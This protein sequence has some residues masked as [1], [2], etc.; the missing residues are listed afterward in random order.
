MIINTTGRIAGDFYML[1]HPAIP[2]YLLDGAQPVIFDAGFSFLGEL[3]ATEVKAVLGDRLPAFC[4]LTHSHFDH[5]GAVATL[6]QHFPGLKVLASAKAQQTLRRPNAIALI[7][8]L[9]RAAEAYARDMGLVFDD[10]HPFQPFEVDQVLREGDRLDVSQGRSIEVIETPGHTWDCLSYYIPSLK[11]LLSS[12]AAGQADSNG[13]IVSD[14]LV[15]YDQ[16]LASIQK[17]SGLAIDLLG[18][19]HLY[20]YTGDDARAYLQQS[21]NTCDEF[22]RLVEACLVQAQGDIQQVMARVRAIEY[23]N[24]S[25]P[26]Q[27]EQA[28]LINLAARIKA[29]AKRMQSQVN[30]TNDRHPL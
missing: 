10:N 1:G 5:C 15:D 2:I 16:Y 27:T 25:G 13:Y 24:N 29:V 14:C 6:Q 4:L 21:L 22:R 20:V 19:G 28:Y 12:E 23:D 3:Y 9:N 26:K 7:R 11:A 8:D 18:L 30:G 17:L